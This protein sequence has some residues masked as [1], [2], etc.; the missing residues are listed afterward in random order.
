MAEMTA[1]QNVPV[2]IGFSAGKDRA[3]PFNEIELDVIFRDEAG[4][5]WRVPAFWAGGRAWRVRFAPPAPGAYTW[6]SVCSDATDAGLHGREGALRAEPYE[7][8]HPLLRHGPVRVSADR[9]HLE[10]ADGTPFFWLGDTWWFGLCT[11]LRWGE[12]FDRLVGD[13]VAKGF[14]VVQIV[15][16]L[17]PDIVPLDTR[18]ANE[19]GVPWEAGFASIR[20]TFFD[21]AD[22][23]IARLVERGLLPCLLGCWG[24]YLR[25]MGLERMKR[26][27]RYLIA[28][29]GAWPVVWCLAGEG[30]MPWYL[31]EDREGDAALQRR[32]WTEIARYVRATDPFAHPITI[33][34]TRVGRD[35]VEDPQVLDVDMLQTGHNG[36]AGIPFSLDCVR[37]AIAREPRMPVVNGEPCYEGI[38]G[39]AWEDVQ[40]VLFWG[41]QLAGVAGYT[42]GA[43]GIWQF[44][45]PE[46]PFGES[47]HGGAWGH[48]PW[49]EAFRLPGSL[50]V[51]LGKG[52]LT[53]FEWWRFEPRPDWLEPPIPDEDPEAAFMAGIPG[54][55]RIGYFRRLTRWMKPRHVVGL[56]G[57]ARYRAMFFDPR[58][59][60]EYDL[61]PVEAD[62]DGR[63]PVPRPP[64]LQDWVLVLKRV[65][66]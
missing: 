27:W 22:R 37:R 64:I 23:R 54:E 55:V 60:R 33:H 58:T 48:T 16:G 41:C 36:Y 43:N 52:L 38:F 8:D 17:C 32:G 47:P 10:H 1:A 65:P 46:E 25:F 15:A 14:T 21:H 51:G 18:A 9:R 4:A 44:N 53:R 12:E 20:P 40:R 42:Y 35:Q 3:D 49:Q 66:G 45:R 29:W 31:S 61:G 7:G 50:Q 30:A 62:A 19:A 59:G 28:R 39:G 57:D 34:P 26:H 63:W 24:Y 5:E 11:R 6:R 2:E 56:E 13:R